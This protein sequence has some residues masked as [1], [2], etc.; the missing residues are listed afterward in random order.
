MRTIDLPAGESL[1]LAVV[2]KLLARSQS[3]FYEYLR[4]LNLGE[5]PPGR[6]YLRYPDYLNWKQ[7]ESLLAIALW[8]SLEAG[9]EDHSIVVAAALVRQGI[10]QPALA[11]KGISLP[12]HL[13]ELKNAYYESQSCSQNGYSQRAAC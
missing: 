2:P 5:L 10:A 4:A 1:P 9:N 7:V 6:K 13:Q 11:L 8:T 3:R 12:Q